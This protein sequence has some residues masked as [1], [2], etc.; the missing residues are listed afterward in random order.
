M[1]KKLLPTTF[2]ALSSLFFISINAQNYQ[3]LSIQSGFNADVIAN[4]TGSS[5]SSTTT[6]VDGVSYAFVSK[7]F[8]LTAASTPLTYGLPSNGLI[9]SVVAS[10]PGL[11]FQMASYSSNNS[12]RLGNVGSSGTLTFTTPIAV[13]TLYMLATGGSGSCNVTATLTFSDSSTQT[14][15]GISISDWYNGSNY[16]IQ[17]IGRINRSNDVLETGSGS[18]PRLYQ[19]SLP[20][21]VSNQSK[22]IQSITVSKSAGSGIANVFAFSGD[23]YTSCPSPTNIT[24]VSDLAGATLSWTAPASAPSSGY[25]YYYST[26]STAPTA[27]TTPSGSVGAGITS[28]TLSGLVTGQTYYFWVRSNCGAS[29]GFWTM[30][31]FM[32]GQ[33]ST[34][35]TTGDLNT[36][37]SSSPTSTSTTTCPGTLTINVPAGYKIK[38]TDVAYS[39]TAQAGGW[40][41]DQRSILICTTNNTSEYSLSTG[42]GS[43]GTLSYNRNNLN[44]A[45]DLTGDVSFE[46][47]AWRTY[48]GTDCNP[49]YNK[50]NNNSW[51]VT[52][53]LEALALSVNETAATAKEKLVY[54]NPF[55]DVIHI[56]KA[57][58]I[59]RI[60]IIDLS[61]AVLKKIESPSSSVYLGDLKAGVYIL[62]ASLKDGSVKNTKIIKR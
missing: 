57:D 54:P 32:T 51:K 15:S 30:K 35:Y 56:E 48:G 55:T 41:S 61:G 6:D 39:M 50:V 43:S 8:Q 1:R 27:A 36:L 20:I 38:S 3:P 2:T 49:T 9:N 7:D 22:P 28:A 19:I 31:E 29:Q 25:D 10:T 40:M 21:D 4:G 16:A 14:F 11:S 45:N 17:G 13:N 44:I 60:S 59:Q 18:N 52:V 26:S 24:Y 42:T 47:R 46:L 33:I 23:A 62:A 37:Y 34:T 58:R 5:M 53:T 12:L